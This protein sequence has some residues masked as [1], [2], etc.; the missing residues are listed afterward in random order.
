MMTYLAL[1]RTD[2]I[3]AAIVGSGVT[4]LPDMLARRPEME[5]VFQALV[6]GY[7]GNR[8]ESLNARSAVRWPEKL[9]KKTPILILA[10]TADWRVNPKQA[11]DMAA[12]LL[13]AKHPFRLVMFEGGE[14][15]LTE[16]RAE[17]DRLTRDW[18]DR[19][20]RDRQPW[21]GLEPHG[22]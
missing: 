15:G 19:Y 4:D 13:A 16:H 20:V 11:L 12:A 6:P 8:D 2:R 14:H 17:V 18:L 21:P 10:G 5:D 7:P 22:D 1:A 3:A 9:A